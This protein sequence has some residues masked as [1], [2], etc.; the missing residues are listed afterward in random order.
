MPETSKQ[1][2]NPFLPGQEGA[3][4][5]AGAGNVNAGRMVSSGV[6]TRKT[7]MVLT[8]RATLRCLFA[9]GVAGKNKGKGAS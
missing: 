8:D 2:E 6:Q 9:N 3:I 1:E 5:T 7:G 4:F